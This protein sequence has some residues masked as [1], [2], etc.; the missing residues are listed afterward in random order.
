M[1][2]AGGCG[3]GSLWR[4]AEGQVKLWVVIIFFAIS[5]SLVRYWFEATDFIEKLGKPIFLPDIFGYGF[6]IILVILAMLIWYIV[7]DWNED[8]NKLVIEM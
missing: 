3:S 6:S 7:I 5:N 4:V 1:V 2:V 8:S